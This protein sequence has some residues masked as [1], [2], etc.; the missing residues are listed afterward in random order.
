MGS[1]VVPATITLRRGRRGRKGS[2]AEE[3]TESGNAQCILTIFMKFEHLYNTVK[4]YLHGLEKLGIS[5]V[6]L[7]PRLEQATKNSCRQKDYIN[8]NIE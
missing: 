8:M 3:T 4:K 6:D 5:T 7:Y 2:K 1:A